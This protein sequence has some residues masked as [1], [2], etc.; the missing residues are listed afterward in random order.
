MKKSIIISVVMLFVCVANIFAGTY[1]VR[2]VNIRDYSH[3]VELVCE[4]GKCIYSMPNTKNYRFYG[5]ITSLRSGDIIEVEEWENQLMGIRKIGHETPSYQCNGGVVDNRGGWYIGGGYYGG[6]AHVG[7][8]SKDG[9]TNVGVG[10]YTNGNGS[11]VVE[12]GGTVAGFHFNLPVSVKKKSTRTTPTTATTTTRTAP[13]TV[14]TTT[15]STSTSAAVLY[16]ASNLTEM[17]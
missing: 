4:G 9:R 3:G 11:K 1:K 10:T 12:V 14:Q 5:F 2:L 7:Y 6:S 15:T 8:T 13:R 17:F 16:N